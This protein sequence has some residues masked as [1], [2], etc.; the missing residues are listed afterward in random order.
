[1][2]RN[3][4]KKLEEWASSKTSETIVSFASGDG[5]VE[6]ILKEISQRAAEGNFHYS[7][8]FAIGLF[9]LLERANA[10]ELVDMYAKCGALDRAKKVLEEFHVHDLICWT[11]LITG[12]V[13][14]GRGVEAL[15]CFEIMQML[16]SFN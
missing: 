5:E 4:A 8:F 2:C 13:E 9:R 14:H 1:M 7:R 6:C 16:L 15:R 12:Y 11:S 10:T 3:D